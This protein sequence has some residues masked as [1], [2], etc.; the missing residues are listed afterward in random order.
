VPPIVGVYWNTIFVNSFMRRVLRMVDTDR[1]RMVREAHQAMRKLQRMEELA[2]EAELPV[3]DVRFMKDTFHL[4]S[5]AREYFFEPWSDEFPERMRQAK[6]E[7]LDRYPLSERERYEIKLDLEPMG[8]S[9]RR[10][11]WLLALVL[12]RKSGYRL[13][14]HILMLYLV[15]RLYRLIQS[16]RPQWIPEFAQK[17]AMG[18]DAVFR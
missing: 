1:E 13:I 15:G 10:L 4:L 3:E 18:M 12:R 11:Q 2:G 6:R 17:S 5:L 9:K 8:L 16:R 7:Y 14:D